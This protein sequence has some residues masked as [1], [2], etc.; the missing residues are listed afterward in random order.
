VPCSSSL[1]RLCQTRLLRTDLRTS[2]SE[3]TR[4]TPST[5]PTKFSGLP[6]SPAA[7]DQSVRYEM[8]RR[9][10]WQTF[11]YPNKLGSI[12]VSAA[13]TVLARRVQ[14]HQNTLVSHLTP[15]SEAYRNASEHA[16]VHRRVQHPRNRIISRSSDSVACSPR[17]IADS[18]TQ[19]ERGNRGRVGPLGKS[20]RDSDDFRPI[21][22]FLFVLAILAR[23]VLALRNVP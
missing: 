4:S 15:G 3:K 18:R 21:T 6:R 8:L 7:T 5:A 12:G 20:P 22:S 11:W 23:Q 17:Q 9:S 2:A 14:V 16:L 13:V 1:R 19:H 10:F